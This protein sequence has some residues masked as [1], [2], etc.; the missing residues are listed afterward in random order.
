M[1]E[2]QLQDA[3]NELT[4]QVYAP[5]FFEKLAQEYGIVPETQEEAIQMLVQAAHVKTAA[6]QQVN[7]QP[8][9]E[10]NTLLKAANHILGI[11]SYSENETKMIDSVAG[12]LLGNS[13]LAAAVESLC[14]F[15]KEQ[16][17]G[18]K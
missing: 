17:G 11:E 6:I 8:R 13:K 4:E 5:V 2:Q 3:F 12:E 16:E 7:D 9:K 15:A 18:N 14:K 10:G 1:T